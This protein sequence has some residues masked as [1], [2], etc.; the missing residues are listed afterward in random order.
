MI[1]YLNKNVVHYES[2]E[3]GRWIIFDNLTHSARLRFIINTGSCA[4]IYM[5]F[6]DTPRGCP[7]MDISLIRKMSSYNCDGVCTRV[8]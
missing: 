5:P 8:N 4:A 2:L 7:D 1:D 6:D 3:S